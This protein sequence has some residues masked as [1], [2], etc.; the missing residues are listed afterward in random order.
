[1]SSIHGH[2]VLQMMLASGESWTV[3][4]GESWTVASLEA[5]IRR[6][7]GEEARF[8]TCSAENLSA[9]QLVAFLEK[10]GKFIAREE[11]FTTAENKICRH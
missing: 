7:F 9:A 3:A 10:K 1:M 8:H 6:R 4:S 11:G 5:A 2:E